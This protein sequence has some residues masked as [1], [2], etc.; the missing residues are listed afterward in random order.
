[1]C[2][3]SVFLSADRPK[4]AFEQYSLAEQE[5]RRMPENHPNKA[6]LHSCQGFAFNH[7]GQLEQA[8]EQF[9]KVGVYGS[10]AV[11]AGRV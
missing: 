5:M 8:F 4:E 2:C 7:T 3:A 10:G 11:A 6:L 1:M 9:V